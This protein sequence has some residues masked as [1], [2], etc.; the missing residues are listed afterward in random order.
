MGY[1]GNRGRELVMSTNANIFD[2]SFLPDF[3]AFEVPPETVDADEIDEAVDTPEPIA[4]GSDLLFNFV[5][6]MFDTG[7][8]NQLILA[9]EDRALV[10]W[11]TVALLT[12][13][14]A[15]LIYPNEFGS[16]LHTLRGGGFTASE[17]AS[18]IPVM[19]EDALLVH[20]RIDSVD[21]IT[22]IIDNEG[23]L[24]VNFDVILDDDARLAFQAALPIQR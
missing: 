11:I 10:Q 22:F 16:D 21:N 8:G 17:I 15:F 5:T 23:L 1:Q 24:Q 18:E 9:G 7:S 13:R 14:G 20:D 12:P 6:G 4:L 19:I 2:E 3:E